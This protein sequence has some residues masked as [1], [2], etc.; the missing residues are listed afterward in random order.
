MS[1]AA[2]AIIIENDHF[3]V[4]K[5][6]K[7]GVEY[8]TLVG[9]RVSDGETPEQAVIREVMEET[10]LTVTS[11]RLVYTEKHPAPYNSQYIYLCTVAPH[12]Q[13]GLLIGSEEEVLNRYGMNMHA[14]FWVPTHNFAKLSFR[15][16]QL[17]AAILKGLK[18]GFPSEQPI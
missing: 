2:R 4:M 17:Q 11:H 3:L 13:I 10:G 5:R 1:T 7:Q 14:P 8:Y 16:P 9:G 18:S 6:A 12:E 15:T